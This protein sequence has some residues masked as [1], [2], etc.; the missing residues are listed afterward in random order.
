MTE[1]PAQI[2]V[3]EDH[4]LNRQLVRVILTLRGHQIKEAVNV[5]EAVQLLHS[6]PIDLV[7]L[8]IQIPGGG[9][10]AVL[11]EIRN[12]ETLASLPVVAVTAFAMMGDQ[13]RLLDAGFDAYISKP[14]DV[15]TFAAQIEAFLPEQKHV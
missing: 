5:S 12:H 15:K 4:P 14:I 3:V 1:Y 7:I 2:L 13:E 11:Q 9:G 6:Q 10:I 8:D